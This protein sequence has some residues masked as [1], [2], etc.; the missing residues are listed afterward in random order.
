MPKK[1]KRKKNKRKEKEF[2]SEVL[3]IARVTRV[4][5]G[6]RRLSFRATVAIGDKKGKV[7]IG[8][9]KGSDVA[10][11]IEKAKRV[12][13]KNMISVPVMEGSIPFSVKTKYGPAEI[14]LKP[15][16]KGRG[17]VAGSV[18]RTIC[19]LAGIRD[20]SSKIISRSKNKL[21]NAKATIEAF[22]LLKN[23][24]KKREENS[25]E[26]EKKTETTEKKKKQEENKQN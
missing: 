24:L 12:A 17:L 2:A 8:V 5:A 23:K 7:G 6:G 4:T 18:V 16:T 14:L 22:K 21:N 19:D 13:K 9:D 25:E 1:N 15:Q 11:A 20:I 26:K 10:Q 3:D